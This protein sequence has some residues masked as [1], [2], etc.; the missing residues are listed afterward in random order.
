MAITKRQINVN[1][2]DQTFRNLVKV[3]ANKKCVAASLFSLRILAAAFKSNLFVSDVLSMFSNESVRPLHK[4]AATE[5][6]D[7]PEQQ[8]RYSWKI[9]GTNVILC[10]LSRDGRENGNNPCIWTM[11]SAHTQEHLR[12]EK[13]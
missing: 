13:T 12:S 2:S 9:P 3:G 11:S 10:G 1:A 4:L 8:Q 6:H 7:E 5:V